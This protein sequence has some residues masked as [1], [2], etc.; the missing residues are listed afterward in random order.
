M[1]TDAVNEPKLNHHSHEAVRDFFLQDNISLYAL[2]PGS[3]KSKRKFF[4]LTDY[5]SKSGGGIFYATSTYTAELTLTRMTEQARHDYTLVYA[6][7]GN[8]PF[9]KFHSLKVTAGPTYSATTRSGY[10]TANSDTPNP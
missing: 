8:N 5:S 9:S 7:T 2:V 3:G 4:N 1:F 10:Y 6:P